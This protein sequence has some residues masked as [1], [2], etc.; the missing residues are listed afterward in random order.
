VT[1]SKLLGVQILRGVAANMVVLYHFQQTGLL[2]K[3]NFGNRYE[4]FSPFRNF[5]TGVDLFFVISGFIMFYVAEFK[6]SSRWSFLM[7]RI[8]RI[9]PLYW[10]V[11]VFQFL[12][13]NIFFEKEFSLYYLVR[14][15]TFMVNTNEI[16]PVLGP[17]WTLQYEMLFYLILGIVLRNSLRNKLIL[18]CI[19]LFICRL[20]LPLG[21]ILI[22]FV[23]GAL[24]FILAKYFPRRVI[25]SLMTVSGI[26]FIFMLFNYD[27]QNGSLRYIFFG[28][29]AIAIVAFA[30]ITKIRFS[31][32]LVISGDYSFSLYLTHIFV[33][34][35]MYKVFSLSIF[36]SYNPFILLVI[37]LLLCNFIGFLCWKFV[38]RP[39]SGLLDSKFRKNVY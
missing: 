8:M 1:R 20:M 25:N 26:L 30:S 16:S 38:E 4:A 6:T 27:L 7:S 17:G 10:V 18:C 36:L 37:G 23:F 11:S 9:A 29:P 24:S 22:E 32:T 39:L 5:F 14:S 31:R 35:L 15:L 19:L 33:V 2:E 34:S 21:N 12:V 28:V 3:Y 13:S